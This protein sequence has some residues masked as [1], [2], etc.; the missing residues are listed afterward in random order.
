MALILTGPTVAVISGS[1]GGTVFARNRYGNYARNRTKPVD[2]G[3]VSQNAYRTRVSN[4]VVAW[5]A[6]TAAQRD[7]FNAK[8]QT[9]VLNNRIGQSFHPSGINLF[10]RT[11]N[12][13][14]FA[15]LAQVTTPPVSPIVQDPES[16]F[17]YV[18]DPG[19]T[20]TC[21]HNLLAAGCKVLIWFMYNV[22]N[23]TYFY[24]GPYP[25]SS[26]QTPASLADDTATLATNAVINAD[27]SMF[28][29]V[30][31]VNADGGAS[32]ARRGRDV[33]PPA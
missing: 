33:K 21:D 12:L 10:I 22:T 29:M 26:Q 13:L 25:Y 11:Y 20:Y 30:R 23:S 15:G 4:A 19:F 32:H 28:G 7:M 9:T 2:P 3:S 18:A 27:S 8:A 5:Q 1:I 24:K 14:D 16:A 6:L 17:V 31:V